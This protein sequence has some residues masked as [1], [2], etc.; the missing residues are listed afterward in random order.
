MYI[1]HVILFLDFNISC[2]ACYSLLSPS[3]YRTPT[4]GT[5]TAVNTDITIMLQQQKAVLTKIL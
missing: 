3:N 2:K 5:S 1:I 4:R